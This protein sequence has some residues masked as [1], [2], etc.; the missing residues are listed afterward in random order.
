MSDQ[1]QSSSV[2]WAEVFELIDEIE[3]YNNYLQKYK[4][5]ESLSTLVRA[6]LVMVQLRKAKLIQTVKNRLTHIPDVPQNILK[7]IFPF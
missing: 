7:R 4:K 1:R 3:E 5:R 6:D 2:D